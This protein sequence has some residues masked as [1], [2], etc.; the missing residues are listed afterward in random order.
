M[1]TRRSTV[2]AAEAAGRFVEQSGYVR[3]NAIDVFFERHGHGPPL[4]LLHGALGTIESCFAACFL[5][6]RNTSV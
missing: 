4:V 1:T 5:S 2:P 3:V 6:S